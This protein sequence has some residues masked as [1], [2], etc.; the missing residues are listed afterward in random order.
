MN[1]LF[2]QNPF[3]ADAQYA[4]AYTYEVY[5][6]DYTKARANYEKL[7]NQ[8]P[9]SPLQNQVREALIRIGGK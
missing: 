8:Y 3:A 6:R 1:N 7:L 9:N 4:I 2:Y 5:L